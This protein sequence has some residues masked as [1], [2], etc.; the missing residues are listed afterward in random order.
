[1]RAHAPCSCCLDRTNVAQFCIGRCLLKLQ[2][3]ALGLS[4]PSTLP[5]LEVADALLMSMYEEV[6][7]LF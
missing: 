7:D 1:M 5:F 3:R 2:L 4:A 6:F